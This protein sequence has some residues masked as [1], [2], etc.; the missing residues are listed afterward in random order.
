MKAT[1]SITA[2]ILLV[3]VI[4]IVFQNTEVV[5]TRLLFATLSMPR[6]LLL[7]LTL[8]IGVVIGLILGT[9][10]QGRPKGE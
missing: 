5:E 9:K 8:L 4:I 2:A 10:L 7:G 6:A 3:L 1:K